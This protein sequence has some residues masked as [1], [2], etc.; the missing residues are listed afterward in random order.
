MVGETDGHTC[1]ALRVA[2]C[3]S[4]RSPGR[5]ALGQA[6]TTARARLIEWL[7]R[8]PMGSDEMVISAPPFEME[9]EFNGQMS[10]TPRATG[11]WGETAS[12]GEIDP[13]DESG[14]NATRETEGLQLSGEGL[15]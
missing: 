15:D 5:K 4:G 8:G 9:C 14:L 2:R 1:P 10:Q 12:Q 6:P 7:T 3:K 13:F 11:K